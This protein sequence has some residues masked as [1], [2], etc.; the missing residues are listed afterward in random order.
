VLE[1]I[2]TGLPIVAT[3]VGGVGEYVEPPVGGMLVPKGDALAMGT[4]IL[5]FVRDESGRRRTGAYNRQR[6]VTTF[7]WRTSAEQ[8]LAAYERVLAKWA[9]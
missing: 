2:A 5:D 6:A 8:L 3:N 1:A 4:E 9:A 7:S